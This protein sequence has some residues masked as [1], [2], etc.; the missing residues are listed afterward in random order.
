MSKTTILYNPLSGEGDTL[1][2]AQELTVIDTDGL[3][4]FL[5]VTSNIDY[6]ELFLGHT[7][8]DRIILLGGDGTLNRFANA[9]YGLNTDASILFYPCGSGNDF[10]RDVGYK[11]ESDFIDIKEYIKNLPTV[12]VDGGEYHF[13]NGVGYGID[14][15]CCVV[16]D[17]KKANNRHQK[18]N[19]TLIAIKGLL[20]HYKPT[21]AVVT[22]DGV[23]HR[24]ERV[25]LAPTMY[26]RYYGGG[27]MPAPRQ[28]R[29]CEGKLSCMV[30]H[31]T[32]KLRTLMI[33]PSIFS[34]SHVKHE[35]CVTILTGSEISIEYD[36]PR[37]LQI[38]GE[39][40]PR[41]KKCTC[42]A[43]KCK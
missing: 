40:I 29:E 11:R 5:D 20:F 30:F 14:G 13:I 1:L 17:A 2:K 38:D 27:M 18:V 24:F 21:G 4:N 39:V 12:S 43:N 26:G 7:E 9:V 15:Y 23:S 37:T 16:G 10:A 42:Y 6:S 8:G 34:G 33:F 28:R 22:V 36:S 25:W 35:N 41:V 3:F 32:G 19:Y 31:G